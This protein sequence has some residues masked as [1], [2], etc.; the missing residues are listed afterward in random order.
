VYD[1]TSVAAKTRHVEELFDLRNP[2]LSVVAN[3]GGQISVRLNSSTMAGARSPASLPARANQ[4]RPAAATPPAVVGRLAVQSLGAHQ[5]YLE[6]GTPEA[7]AEVLRTVYLLKA[8]ARKN[9][10]AIMISVPSGRDA[11]ITL[12]HPLNRAT[13][14]ED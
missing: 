5:W 7:T 11:I 4:G 10:V 2:D 3:S 13:S 8:L 9:R 6:G 1:S 14:G 12:F